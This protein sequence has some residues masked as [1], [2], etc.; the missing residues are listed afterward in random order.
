MSLKEA[1]GAIVMRIT[2]NQYVMLDSYFETE[3]T[4]PK[5]TLVLM[6]HLFQVTAFS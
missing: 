5:Y 4:C 2:V 3:H 6:A 1:I